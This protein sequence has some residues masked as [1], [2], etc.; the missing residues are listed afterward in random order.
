MIFFPSP[1]PPK[2]IGVYFSCANW[3]QPLNRFC[4][5]VRWSF[6]PSALLTTNK[7]VYPARKECVRF[8]ELRKSMCI[9]SG[10]CVCMLVC[11]CV[12]YPPE[13]AVHEALAAV[14]EFL[15]QHHDKVRS[16]LPSVSSLYFSPHSCCCFLSGAMGGA[17][18]QTCTHA[19]TQHIH[20]C[21]R[22]LS[23]TLRKLLL[24]QAHGDLQWVLIGSLRD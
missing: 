23:E 17:L 5:G 24:S 19:R 14:R 2:P 11:V 18:W 1:H 20:A 16:R 3:S 8:V 10:V 21:I 15:D 13:Q 9:Y 4:R 22:I 12:G 7:C 6:D